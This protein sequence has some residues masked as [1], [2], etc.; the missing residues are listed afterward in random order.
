[1]DLIK[2]NLDKQARGI[3]FFIAHNHN[4][5]SLYEYIGQSHCI[6]QRLGK[7]ATGSAK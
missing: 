3:Y 7:H 4:G 6:L 2:L 5:A 1:M